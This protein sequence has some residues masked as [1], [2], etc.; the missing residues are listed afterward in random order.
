MPNAASSFSAVPAVEK[1]P[2]A[3]DLVMAY[4]LLAELGMDDLS[5]AHISARVPGTQD[6]F[7]INSLGP[8]FDEITTQDLMR[9]DLEGRVLSDPEGTYNETG[10]N[11]HGTIYEAHPQIQSVIHT[12]TLAG[13]A[14]SAQKQGLLPLSQFAYHFEGCLGYHDYNG[15]VLDE[16][17]SGSLS[18]SVKN[19]RAVILRNH[20][21][22]TVGTSVPQTF[23]F[24]YYL[25]KACQVQCLATK[26]G[27]DLIIPP[28]EVR[29]KAHAQMSAFEKNLGS[30]DWEG[31]VRRYQ[32][33]NPV[34]PKIK[35]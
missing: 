22:L 9:L 27:H 13:T 16:A 20:G 26:S 19:N 15:L 17:E 8:F 1:C 31:L 29:E 24:M 14:V 4:R 3:S 5:Y 25:E 18:S 34:L 11:I 10:R 33:L 12:H 30:R 35:K 28:K 2:V 21:L 32:R 6:Q 7:Y 23:F